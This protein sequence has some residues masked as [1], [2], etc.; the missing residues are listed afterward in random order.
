MKQHRKDEEAP[1][2]SNPANNSTID[3]AL[4][5]ALT[6]SPSLK[7]MLENLNSRNEK[8]ANG[9]CAIVFTY[10]FRVWYQY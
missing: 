6:R 3:K 8:E 5:E 7:T 4:E 10:F 2:E 9:K 1:K